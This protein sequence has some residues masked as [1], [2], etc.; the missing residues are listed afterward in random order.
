MSAEDRT[1]QTRATVDRVEDGGW[2]VVLVGEDESFSVDLPLSMLPAGTEAGSRLVINVSLDA[3][4]TREA[5][6]RVAELQDRLE[7]RSGTQ[8]QKNFK[9]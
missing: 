3:D 9:L 6:D 1:Q 2:A 8:G 4:A 7:K 5:R